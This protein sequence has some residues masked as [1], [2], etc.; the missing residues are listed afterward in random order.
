MPGSTFYLSVNGRRFAIPE[1]QDMTITMGGLTNK[2]ELGNGDG[3]VDFQKKVVPG[4]IRGI[5]CR[6]RANNGDI[7]S[8][9][10]YSGL[11]G[12]SVVVSNI[13]GV[14]EGLGSLV[15]DED[16]LKMST[17]EGKTEDFDFVCAYGQGL[18]RR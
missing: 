16:G 10:S 14:Y 4:A 6:L 1:D 2:D 11:D 13:D 8:L 17:Q 18:N 15:F 5:A 7:E 9:S 3:S 12:L